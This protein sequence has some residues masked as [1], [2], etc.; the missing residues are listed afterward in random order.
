M[1]NL[2]GHR[3]SVLGAIPGLKQPSQK[4]FDTLIWDALRSFSQ[5]Q[6]VFVEGESKKIGNVSVP[7]ALIDAMRMSACLNVHLPDDERVALLMEDY[8][9]WVRH[10]DDFC[11]RL[12]SLTALKGR[13]VVENWQAQ[14]RSGQWETVVQNLLTHH[15]DPAYWQSIHRNF[16]Q[17]KNAKTIA[18]NDRSMRAMADLAHQLLMSAPDAWHIPQTVGAV[19]SVTAPG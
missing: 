12:A 8:D 4:R 18:P 2:A 9:T 1:E 17:F 5:D 19:P 10:G 13:C 3:S 11:N 15:Y 16:V 7:C 6:P 14:A